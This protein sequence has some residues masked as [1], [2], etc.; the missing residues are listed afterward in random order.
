MPHRCVAGMLVPEDASECECRCSEWEKSHHPEDYCE[1]CGRLNPVW[2]S[3]NKLFNRI[4]GGPNG[5]I[6]P[7]CFQNKAKGLG[8]TVMFYA[9]E[10]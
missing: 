2:T 3:D 7:V 4:N 10:L 5:I 1:L 8:I 9:K 6:C